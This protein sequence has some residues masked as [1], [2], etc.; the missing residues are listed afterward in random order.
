MAATIRA[1]K[2]FGSLT[3]EG[4]WDCALPFWALARGIDGG[5]DLWLGDRLSD[6]QEYQAQR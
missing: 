3:V 1:G 2:L 6:G 5:R 4:I